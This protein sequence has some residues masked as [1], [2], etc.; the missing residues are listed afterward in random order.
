MSRLATGGI[1][2]FIIY[3]EIWAHAR[4]TCA[5]AG[6]LSHDDADRPRRSLAQ[7]DQNAHAGAG[8]QGCGGVVRRFRSPDGPSSA[9][10]I[11]A[12]MEING[13]MRQA[14]GARASIRQVF[15]LL[16]PRREKKSGAGYRDRTRDL[17]FTKPLLYQLS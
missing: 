9:W 4:N 14:K 13:D 7:S 3:P 16:R 11:D 5:D 1:P 17:R 2:D 12:R 8:R 10:S 15:Q 6:Y